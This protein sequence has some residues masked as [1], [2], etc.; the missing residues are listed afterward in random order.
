MSLLLGAAVASGATQAG[1][2]LVVGDSISAGYGVPAHKVWV[3]DLV[4][5]VEQAGY[6]QTS[7]MNAS[8]SGDTSAG[9]LSRLPQLLRQHK[10]KIVLLELGGNDGLRGLPM[11]ATRQNLLQM[12]Q[13]SRRSGAQVLLAGMDV[14]PSLGPK[15]VKEFRALY[16][17]VAKAGGAVLMPSFIAGVAVDPDLMQSDGIHPNTLAQPKLAEHAWKYLEPMLKAAR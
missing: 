6:T 3:N 9:G 15:Y 13:M 8:V 12:V 14:P 10:P 1:V 7:V 5:R 2:V 11:K 17:E 16:P 4:D